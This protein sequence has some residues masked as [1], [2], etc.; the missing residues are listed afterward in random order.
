MAAQDVRKL[1]P[2]EKRGTGGRPVAYPWQDFDRKGL[3]L[4]EENGAPD[5]DDHEWHQGVFERQMAE[6]SRHAWNKEP[7]PS[8]VRRRVKKLIETFKRQRGS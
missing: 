1:W 2:G 6:W 3:E 5:P 8:T 7:A 4:L